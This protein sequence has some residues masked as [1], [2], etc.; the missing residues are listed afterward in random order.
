MREKTATARM[1]PSVQLYATAGPDCTAFE[2]TS[3]PA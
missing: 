3:E 1:P 2:P